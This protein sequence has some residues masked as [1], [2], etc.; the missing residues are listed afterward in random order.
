M[1]Q[2]EAFE[3]WAKSE[4]K[5][6]SEMYFEWCEKYQHY[7]IDE[8]DFAWQAWQAATANQWQPID[9]APKD[10]TFLAVLDCA[11]ERIICT[12]RYAVAESKNSVPDSKEFHRERVT[13]WMPLPP[14][15]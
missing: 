13:H 8:V 5:N 15:P 1:N 6:H 3:K 9:S 4:F 11:G 7:A 14:A 12:M 2:R 10:E